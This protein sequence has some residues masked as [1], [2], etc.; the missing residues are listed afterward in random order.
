MKMKSI[1][2]II[3]GLT[4]FVAG[5]LRATDVKASRFDKLEVMLLN[6]DARIFTDRFPESKGA[7]H[8]IGV[9]RNYQLKFQLA[10][11]GQASQRISL[12]L[13]DLKNEAGEAFKGQL[14]IMQLLPVHVEGNT[15]GSLINRPGGPTPDSWKPYFIRIAPF[16]VFEVVQDFQ[17]N[18]INLKAGVIAA[19]LLQLNILADCATGTYKGNLHIE[20]QSGNQVVPFSFRVYKTVLPKNMALQS[21]HWLSADPQNLTSGAVPGWWSREHWE[22]LKR[23]GRLLLINGDNMMFTPL[24]NTAHPLI[25][26][27]IDDN[28]HISF[29]YSRFDRWVKT[30]QDIGFKYFDG[31]HL[32]VLEN[33][34]YLKN[35]RTG[36]NINFNET[37]AGVNWFAFL[38]VFLKDF[39]NHL[40]KKGFKNIYI[41]HLYDEPGDLEKYKKYSELLKRCM[42]GTRCIDAINSNPGSFADLVDIQVFNLNGIILQKN[43][44]VKSRLASHKDVWLYNCSSPYPPY[45]NRHLDLPLTENRLWPLLSYKYGATG[46]LWWAANLYRGVA[47]EFQT[48][49]GPSPS[50]TPVHPPGDDW[51]YY[52]SPNGLI[53]SLRIMSFKEGMIDVTLLQL[54]AKTNPDKVQELTAELIHPGIELGHNRPFKDYL[55]TADIYKKSYETEPVKFYDMRNKIL[56]CLDNLVGQ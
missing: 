27:R 46:Y 20:S 25:Q 52:R 51:L 36:T 24:I 43:K 28:K 37:A 14:K 47:N 29:D 39:N 13:T 6:Q 11:R 40:E 54:L 4:I 56:D 41:Q 32:S 3:L 23:A 7:A 42:P 16:D 19:Y 44:V 30:F 1:A 18:K 21:V 49:L 48:S 50:G 45:P 55:T 34:L 12:K 17:D 2:R 8:I 9:P 38:E 31:Q 10:L 15:Q 26:T 35:S 33:D 22:L 5:Q 53:P